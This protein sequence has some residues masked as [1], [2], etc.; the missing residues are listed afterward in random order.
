MNRTFLEYLESHPWL[1][2]KGRPCVTSPDIDGLLCALVMGHVLDWECVGF[3]DGNQ[4]A[5]WKEPRHIPWSDAV[6]L[7]VEIL[8]PDVHSIGNHLLAF[9]EDDAS[10]LARSF[11]GLMNP[12]LWRGIHFVPDFPRKYPFGTFPLLYCVLA[13][14][15]LL[16]PEPRHL[17]ALY[18]PDSGLE[19]A[20]VYK[21]NALDWLRAMG[22][23]DPSSPLAP[24][25]RMVSGQTVYGTLKA[26][27][28]V[29]SLVAQAKFGR[30][31]KAARFDPET[32]SDRSRAARLWDLL[33]QKTGWRASLPLLS[34][35]VF[36]RRFETRR[37]PLASKGR[38]RASFDAA[39]RAG[40][41]SL[42]ATGRTSEGLSYTLPT[43]NVPRFS[44]LWP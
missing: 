28:E 41:L 20:V 13:F 17:G 6:F 38:A 7:D 40:A 43:R 44:D 4:I 5:L 11:P 31:Q 39:A 19:N 42:A 1:T 34:E 37:S 21:D 10:R 33:R 12:N 16:D 35:P 26:L 32:A 14:R 25:C 24:L 27:S 36:V 15:G 18:Y 30:K 22:A 3:Y 23:E 29:Q 8:R 9:D 2:E